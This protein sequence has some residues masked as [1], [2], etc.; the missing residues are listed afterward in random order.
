MPLSWASFSDKA[1]KFG[2][3]IGWLVNSALRSYP[4]C[5][6]LEKVTA[7]FLT[8]LDRKLDTC[9]QPLEQITVPLPPVV[10]A[11]THVGLL[12]CFCVGLLSCICVGVGFVLGRST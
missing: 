8:S 10:E 2:P 6:R 12:G 4:V 11:A 3:V 5:E 1:V 9:S 7:D